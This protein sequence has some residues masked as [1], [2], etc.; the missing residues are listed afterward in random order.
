M[1]KTLSTRCCKTQRHLNRKDMQQGGALVEV[2]VA[3]ALFLSVTVGMVGAFIHTESLW[4]VIYDKEVSRNDSINSAKEQMM[5]NS[6]DQ[7]W[8]DVQQLGPFTPIP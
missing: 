3:S 2:L 6:Y 1:M 8:A 4:V 5:I 7:T